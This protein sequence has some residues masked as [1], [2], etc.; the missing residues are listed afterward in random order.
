M[1]LLDAGPLK[2]LFDP[3]D[4]YHDRCQAVFRKIREDLIT[5]VPVLV[6]TFYLLDPASQGSARLREFIERDGLTVWF[7]DRRA[8]DRSLNLMAQYSD[9]PMDLA[10][11]SLV[12]AAEALKT[13][14]IFTVDRNDFSA[15]RIRQGHGH[16]AFEILG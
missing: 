12:T 11:A 7:L 16:K 6:E 14:K 15:Y 5:T 4:S 1:I 3:K 10:D 2:A 9:H 8:L 13:R